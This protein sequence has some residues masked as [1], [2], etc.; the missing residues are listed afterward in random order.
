MGSTARIGILL[1]IAGQIGLQAEGPASD[2]RALN[3]IFGDR[4]VALNV[5]EARKHA[6]SLPPAAS[7]DFLREWLLPSESHNSIRLSA[8][9]I[10]NDSLLAHSGGT[11]V[12][13]AF[14]LV[15]TADQLNRLD[16]LQRLIEATRFNEEIEQRNRLALLLLVHVQRGDIEKALTVFDDLQTRV[17]AKVYP[18]LHERWPETLVLWKA[19]EVPE[20]HSAIAPLLNRI[21]NSQA[22]AG[23]CAGPDVWDR[24]ISA[25]AA[26]VNES[27]DRANRTG[28]TSRSNH[29]IPS[30][31]LQNWIPVSH[32]DCVTRAHGFPR[33]EWIR[34][35]GDVV[36]LISRQYDYLYYRIP[37][38]GDFEVE[39]D[40]AGFDYRDTELTIHGTCVVPQF[41][42]AEIVL[43]NLRGDR[44]Q[45]E[46]DPPL[47]QSNE[48]IHHRAVVK[49]GNYTIFLNGREVFR[50]DISPNAS[51]WLAIRSPFYGQSRVRDV[52]ISGTPD[53]P[54]ELSLSSNRELSGW[55][56]DNPDV[57]RNR[58]SWRY[59]GLIGPD[60]GIVSPVQP[61]VR[62]SYHENLLRYECPLTE[63]SQVEYEFYYQKD[64][65]HVHP[66]LDRRAYLLQPE[67]VHIHR[68]TDGIWDRSGVNP[69]NKFI[70]P[71]YEFRSDALPLREGWNHLRATLQE[72]R[73]T[74]ELNDQSVYQEQL[75]ALN[76]R[77]F[78]LFHYADQTEVRVRN[79]K[80]RGD[81]PKQLPVAADQELRD[82]RIDKLDAEREQLSDQAE[83]SFQNREYNANQF[84]R[85]NSSGQGKVTP[86][87][88]GLKMHQPGS[89]PFNNNWIS[90]RI[91]VSGDFDIETQFEQLALEV[92]EHG[93]T[94]VYLTVVT[95]DGDKTHAH[96]NR[97]AW[98]NPNE[99][100]KTDVQAEFNLMKP[101]G[102]DIQFEGRHPEESTSGRL[103][104][105][106]RGKMM[107]FLFA[108]G[109][110]PQYRIIY[111]REVNDLPLM[112]SGIRLAAGT[113][114]GGETPGEANVVWKRLNVKAD[115][116][117][118][119]P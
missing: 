37:L 107:Y 1:L 98:R 33:A 45:I 109:N 18:E 95:T 31:E 47:S 76:G 113:W 41:S 36:N 55:I 43:Q 5:R 88:T 115:S 87:E 79:V 65:F 97:G 111:E 108:E 110:S 81:W 102:V 101:T 100:L 49:D 104:I 84:I 106:R 70:N 58:Q 9:F 44:Q 92:S 21:H 52:R 38:Q 90:P 24:H 59:D 61:Q 82:S 78:G 46:V 119:T 17:E 85:Y 53:I 13:P 83:Y 29:S 20:L 105:A 2:E 8:E 64:R 112:V 23:V 28:Q 99:R 69:N 77:T 26:I 67:G 30:V 57:A 68:L 7:F 54:E 34:Q 27:L 62:G 74:L 6:A 75:T 48:W 103:R 15:A 71:D 39:C 19:A 40:L 114:A 16:E 56:I 116:I 96:V 72:D 118:E 89:K 10:P 117:E 11:L 91:R 32:G 66:A 42:H 22:R 3:Q 51:A 35:R 73:V 86:S 94:S 25:L 12:S 4:F 63:K 80:Y 60:G 50:Q 93:G 14:D